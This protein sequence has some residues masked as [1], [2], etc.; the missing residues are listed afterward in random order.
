M[1]TPFFLME[2]L[3]SRE[4]EVATCLL[5]GDSAMEVALS[6]KISF[7]TVRVHIRH[8]YQ[9][10]NASNRAEFVTAILASTGSV[11]PPSTQ[12]P[13]EAPSV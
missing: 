3:T 4:R 13:T 8:I 10:T 11:A 1:P 7:H 12:L 5:H 9:K 2:K 6:L